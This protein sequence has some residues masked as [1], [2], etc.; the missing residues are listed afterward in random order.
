MTSSVYVIHLNVIFKRWAQIWRRRGSHVLRRWISLELTHLKL[1][2]RLSLQ[3][4]E[5]N[6]M[7]HLKCVRNIIIRVVKWI[8]QNCLLHVYI[9]KLLGTSSFL[10]GWSLYPAWVKILTKLPIMLEFR[11]LGCSL[12]SNLRSTINLLKWIN[13]T[14]NNCFFSLSKLKTWHLIKVSKLLMLNKS[15][16]ESEQSRAKQSIF[17]FK[18]FLNSV[19]Y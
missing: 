19:G 6:Y 9:Y 13:F 14:T 15:V 7:L 10:A 11:R 18:H 1:L 5:V 12:S 4:D 2:Y 8:Q 3:A 16:R 17:C